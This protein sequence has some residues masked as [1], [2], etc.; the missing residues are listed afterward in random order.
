MR[1]LFI[2]LCFAS[3]LACN[4][5]KAEKIGPPPPAMQP[6]RYYYF[7]KANVYF[8]SANKEY[9]FL[10]NNG[11]SWETQKQI[12]AAMQSM[13]DKSVF[14]DSP[15]TPVWKDNENH[16]LL[17]SALLYASPND[18]VE[19]KPRPAVQK[20]PTDSVVKKEKKGLRKFFDKIFGKKKKDKQ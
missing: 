9:V 17:Y 5:N 8:D 15:Q 6:A 16:K 10:G 7:P 13:M 19:D 11:T 14:I 18:T 1:H 4:N 3:C 20:P 2:I 12:P